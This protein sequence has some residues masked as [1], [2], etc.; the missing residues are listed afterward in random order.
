[1]K[2]RTEKGNII[3]SKKII[4][5]NLIYNSHHPQRTGL[6]KVPAQRSNSVAGRENQRTSQADTWIMFDTRLWGNPTV[7]VFHRKILYETV[8]VHFTEI[9]DMP[10]RYL[11][12]STPHRGRHIFVGTRIVTRRHQILKYWQFGFAH[13]K[14]QRCKSGVVLPLTSPGGKEWVV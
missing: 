3:K 6:H 13:T 8:Y 10:F 7:A 14:Q 1:M 9:Q 11:Q 4:L 12:L 2:R 5:N